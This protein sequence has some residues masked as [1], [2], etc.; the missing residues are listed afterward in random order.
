[1]YNRA[2]RVN[3]SDHV[4]LLI[5]RNEFSDTYRMEYDTFES[6]VDILPE[7]LTFNVATAHLSA[8]Y[9]EPIYPELVCAS[10]LRYLAGGKKND[11]RDWAEVPSSSYYRLELC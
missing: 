11:I 9:M 3:W 5:H 10:G 1:M 6:F 8:P 4:E 2:E 7:G